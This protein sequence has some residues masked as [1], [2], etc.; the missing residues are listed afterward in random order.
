MKCVKVALTVGLL[1]SGGVH[2]ATA[3]ETLE[4][5]QATV[6]QLR[7]D[8]ETKIDALETKINRMESEQERV[9]E[10]KVA[11]ASD[12][13]KKSAQE[14][15][16]K[17][18][19]VGRYEGEFGRGGLEVTAPGGLAKVTLGGYMDHE[20]ENFQNTNSS[21]DQHRWIINVGATIG[22]RLRFFS[23]YEIEHGGPNAS[24]GGE[25]KVEQAYVDFLVEEWV[26]LRAGAVLVPFG[27][28]N[29]YHDSDMRDLTDRP[30]M[31]RDIIPTTWTESGVGLFGEFEPVIGDYEGLLISYEAHVINGLDDGF[32]DTGLRNARGSLGG[33][34]NNNKAVAG[35]VVLSPAVGHELGLSGYHGKYNNDGDALVGGALDFL[36]TWGPVELIGEAARF[37][38][39]QPAGGADIADTFEGFRLQANYH[40]WPEF[41]ND[42]WL[43]RSFADPTF[44]LVSRYD[45]ARI[46]DDADAGTGDNEEDRITLGLNYRPVE[47][48]VLKAEYQWNETENE[49]LERGNNDGFMMSIAMGF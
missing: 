10:E 2:P 17:S 8:Y 13:I 21:F 12:E 18:E 16:W 25:A 39:D 1:L 34:N 47:S 6:R 5:I 11:A 23:E 27:R 22:E 32:S 24:G 44:T 9:L 28:L 26:N 31:A 30:L 46:D 48:W 41:L 35:R 15:S 3:Q 38:A 37:E 7:Q 29:I 43:G 14:G 4:E 49:A 20:F 42:T 33:D 36:S 19:Y 40:F 45:W